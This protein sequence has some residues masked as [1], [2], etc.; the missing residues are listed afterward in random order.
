MFVVSLIV[1][2]LGV[3]LASYGVVVRSES[4]II[5]SSI[6]IL[7]PIPFVMLAHK[8][9]KG[10]EKAPDLYENAIVALITISI[11]SL[12]GYF[13]FA[14][15]SG[16]AVSLAIFIGTILSLIIEYASRVKGKERRVKENEKMLLV[17]GKERNTT[18]AQGSVGLQKEESDG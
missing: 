9:L 13:L 17:A 5:A 8:G 1:L 15:V 14:T 12:L 3:L 10:M 7:F 4:I 16:K 2:I 11:V 18:N 6:L